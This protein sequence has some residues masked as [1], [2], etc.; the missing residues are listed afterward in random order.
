MENIK[1]TFAFA[2]VQCERILNGRTCTYHDRGLV[3]VVVS[4]HGEGGVAEHGEPLLVPGIHALPAV[5]FRAIHDQQQ[6]KPPNLKSGCNT[7]NMGGG[8]GRGLG[9]G[10][11]AILV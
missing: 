11:Q 8:S 2:N 6:V 4:E 10:L 5:R 1:K 9:G 7:V 3:V